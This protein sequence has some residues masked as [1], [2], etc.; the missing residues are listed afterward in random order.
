MKNGI[1][2]LIVQIENFHTEVILSQLEALKGF[3]EIDLFIPKNL[4]G[5][6]S[7]FCYPISAVYVVPDASF[8][9][10]TKFLKLLEYA[11]IVWKLRTL[12]KTNQYDLMV[13]NSLPKKSLKLKLLNL[14]LPKG[15]K[16]AIVHNLSETVLRNIRTFDRYLVLSKEVYQHNFPDGNDRFDYF[17]PFLFSGVSNTA[18]EPLP[19]TEEEIRIGILGKTDYTKRNYLR[20]MSGLERWGNTMPPIKF[21]IIGETTDRL[22]DDIRTKQVGQFFH[23]KRGYLSFPEML[24]SIAEMDAVALLIDPD[25]D[26]FDKYNAVKITGTSNLVKYCN[27]PLILHREFR[28]DE[29]LR[30]NC[31][32]YD[33]SIEEI[34]ESVQNGT[35]TREKIRNRRMDSETHA[36]FLNSAKDRYVRILQN[37]LREPRG[38]KIEIS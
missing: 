38:R 37:L 26:S 15:K 10:K 21:H 3:A 34:I 36:A 33:E 20:L 28:I 22:L 9:K 23:A 27:L 13:F 18:V 19:S 29:S 14:L 11:G 2:I 32:F 17:E 5:K 1:K 25:T 7:L 6:D 35:L 24:R 8:M 12:H 16:V 4:D 31:L 30:G